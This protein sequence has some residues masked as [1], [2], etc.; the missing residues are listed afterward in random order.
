MLS[1]R[2]AKTD[3]TYKEIWMHELNQSLLRYYAI[4][5]QKILNKKLS[6]KNLIVDYAMRYGS[7][8]IR[9]RLTF[10]Q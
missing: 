7:P 6:K 10:M 5:Q 3:K 2:L 9:E 4:Q 1:V 8:S